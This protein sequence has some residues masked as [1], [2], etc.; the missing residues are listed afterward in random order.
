MVVA[1]QRIDERRDDPRVEVQLHEEGCGAACVV[2][3]L[4]DIGVIADQLSIMARLHL[5]SG[6]EELARCLNDLSG[7]AYQWFGG[8]LNIE[9][10]LGSEHI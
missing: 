4:A 8:V 9:P 3:L 10:P 5:P 1:W 2:M 6:A 7:P